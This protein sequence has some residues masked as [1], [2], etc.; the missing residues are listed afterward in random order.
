M[1]HAGAASARGAAPVSASWRRRDHA[2]SA[3][4]RLSRRP[5]AAC[6][7]S[8]DSRPRATG[9][10]AGRRHADPPIEPTDL[11]GC[12][13]VGPLG[14]PCRRAPRAVRA[15][16]A[17]VRR[18]A[19]RRAS[20]PPST[21][22]ALSRQPRRPSGSSRAASTGPDRRSRP[23]RSRS[24]AACRHPARPAVRVAPR[25]V[26]RSAVAGPIGRRRLPDGPP[27]R[28]AG[29][30][31]RF[32]RR[33][34][35]AGAPA[36]VART[37]TT[38]SCRPRAAASRRSTCR[39]RAGVGAAEPSGGRRSTP[40]RCWPPPAPT[41]VC[42]TRHRRPRS[43]RGAAAASTPAPVEVPRV[44]SRPRAGS[45]DTPTP[46][47]PAGRATSA[48]TTPPADSPGSPAPVRET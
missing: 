45:L 44:P 41:T 2:G 47:S 12:P 14:A 19:A 36:V 24:A 33:P 15:G 42:R 38:P 22:R 6:T 31:D 40:R 32:G 39:R 1:P 34:S 10:R 18:P 3:V 13:V 7:G 20:A 5:A 21:G 26:R 27:N 4:D 23:P 35:A 16:R 46:R 11:S 30:V 9:A 43:R 17:A 28:R 48:V 29:P 25:S 8:P 37:P